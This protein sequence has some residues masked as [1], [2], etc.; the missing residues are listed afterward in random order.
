MRPCL[1]R[2]GKDSLFGIQGTN[3]PWIIGRSVSSRCIRM[4]NED[5]ADLYERVRVGAKM[6][7]L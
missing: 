4:L 7:V 6:V 2:G 5:V 3:E 1:D